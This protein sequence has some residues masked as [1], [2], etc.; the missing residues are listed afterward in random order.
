MTTQ[1]ESEGLDIEFKHIISDCV[2]CGSAL[3]S[4]NGTTPYNAVYGRVPQFLPEINVPIDDVAPGTMR[5]EQRMRE[6]SVQVM[7]E[8]T[9]QARIKRALNTKTRPAGQIFEYK[10]GDL[11][12][13]RRTASTNDASGWKGPAKLIDNT[14]ITP[15]TLTVSYQRDMP[16]KVRLQDVR[17][18]LDYFCFMAAPHTPCKPARLSGRR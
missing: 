1:G 15:G 18:H 6:I 3:L 17:R 13:F 7:V 4:I 8:G 12:D 11:V 16:I 5:H 10:I 9:A 2:F 14:D